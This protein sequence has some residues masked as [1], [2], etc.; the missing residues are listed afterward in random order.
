MYP[1]MLAATAVVAAPFLVPEPEVIGTGVSDNFTPIKLSL[2]H[3]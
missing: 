2:I 1:L 3:I